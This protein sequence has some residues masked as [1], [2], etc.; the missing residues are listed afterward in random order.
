M[1]FFITAVEE[2]YTGPKIQEGKITEEF[3]LSLMEYYKAQKVLHRKYAYKVSIQMDII[4]LWLWYLDVSK[5]YNF[6]SAFQ[7]LIDIKKYLMQQ[8]T[9]VDVTIPDDREFTVCGDIHGQFYDLMNIFKINGLPSAT[10]PY[11]SFKQDC[12]LKF[13]LCT[14]WCNIRCL[15][16][17]FQWFGLY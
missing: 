5:S 16:F 11:V 15:G 7:I 13:C 3:V 14:W 4:F 12:W 17:W 1:W 8:P 10:N 2:S 6:I 9:L